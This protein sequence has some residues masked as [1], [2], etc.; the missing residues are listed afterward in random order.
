M[1][2]K[3]FLAI[4]VIFIALIAYV[5][6]VMLTTRD[7]S[8]ADTINYNNEG[9]SMSITYCRPFKKGRLIFGSEQEGALQPYG[10]YWRTGANE[11]TEITFENDVIFN[12]EKVNAGTYRFYTV[13]GE[14]EWTVALNTELGEWGYS[15][16]DYKLDVHKSTVLAEKTN[17]ATEQFTIEYDPQ[18]NHVNIVLLWDKTMV[19][20]PVSATN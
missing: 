1:K 6:Y 4:A 7:H 15:E 14:K 20:I 18:G 13:P 8:P 5:A 17:E 11:A 2:R 19:K 16:P 3:I 9:V 10:Q 12:G